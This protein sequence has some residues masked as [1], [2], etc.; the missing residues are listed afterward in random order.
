MPLLFLAL[1]SAL[2]SDSCESAALPSPLRNDGLVSARAHLQSDG[3]TAQ[4]EAHISVRTTREEEAGRVQVRFSGFFNVTATVMLLPNETKEEASARAA[5]WAVSAAL[6]FSAVR[7]P[8]AIRFGAASAHAESTLSAAARAAGVSADADA[9]GGNADATA[10]GGS[11]RVGSSNVSGFGMGGGN[12]RNNGVASAAGGPR[13]SKGA[14][15]D[16]NGAAAVQARAGI[17]ASSR[18]VGV[19]LGDAAQDGDAEASAR[20]NGTAAAAGVAT[21]GSEYMGQSVVRGANGTA[22]HRRVREA[23]GIG[24]GRGVSSGA[25]GSGAAAGHGATASSAHSSHN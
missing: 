17:G 16:G 9:R 4:R 19:A 6:N 5:P 1:L 8:V 10:L 13:E 23:S 7:G 25:G 24:E 20:I 3:R 11:V 14:S 2:C 15:A 21:T 18:V 12:A 22:T